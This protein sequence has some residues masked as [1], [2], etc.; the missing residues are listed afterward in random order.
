MYKILLPIT[1]VPELVW[2]K[3]KDLKGYEESLIVVNNWTV[4][5]IAQCAQEFADQGAEVWDCS[6]NLGLGATWNFGMQRMKEDNCDF[7]IFLAPSAIFTKS[8]QY[9]I[10]AILE[11]ENKENRCRYVCSKKATLHCFAHTRYGLELG[12]LF[13]EN[14]WPIY[15]EDTDYCHRSKFNGIGKLPS[16]IS[17]RSSMNIDEVGEVVNLNLN[18]VVYSQSFSVSCREDASLMDLH[19]RNCNRWTEY[20]VAKWGGQHGS[21]QYRTPFGNPDTDI[22]RWENRGG[23]WHPDYPTG[24]LPPSPSKR[25]LPSTN[26]DEKEESIMG[27]S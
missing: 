8:I 11:Q 21:E 26:L 16:R 27:D 10:D 2:Q 23:F 17:E 4:P 22:N 19:M 6:Y 3:L 7:V 13:D 25:I 12:G 9:F 14:F 20:Y 5:E 1:N 18:D 24:W 15:Y